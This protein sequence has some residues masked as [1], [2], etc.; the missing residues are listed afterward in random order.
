VCKD[1]HGNKLGTADHRLEIP[2]KIGETSEMMFSSV[3]PSRQLRIMDRIP[4][5]LEQFILG[6]VKIIPELDR[7]FH[8]GDILHLYFHLY[9]VPLDAATQQPKLGMKYLL[10][11]EGQKILEISR[12][13][14]G[15]MLQYSKERVIVARPLDLKNFSPGSYL[16]QIEATD[17]ATGKVSRTSLDFTILPG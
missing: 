15:D 9:N 11:R 12:S 1:V 5:R 8:V 6:D 4:E 3:I 7:R 13:G 10:S 2:K 16:L 17:L 14:M